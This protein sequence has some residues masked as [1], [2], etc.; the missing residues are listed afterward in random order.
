MDSK[1]TLTLILSRLISKVM[2]IVES[3][4]NVK[5]KPRLGDDSSTITRLKQLLE[6]ALRT[7]HHY[8]TFKNKLKFCSFKKLI[9]FKI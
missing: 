1:S 8:T 2:V 4:S 7:L 5:D 9:T 6:V 3:D